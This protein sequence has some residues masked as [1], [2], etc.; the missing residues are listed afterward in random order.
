[1][2]SVCLCSNYN[3]IREWQITQP[4]KHYSSDG[5]HRFLHSLIPLSSS[6]FWQL[7]PSFICS[8]DRLY[9]D[10]LFHVDMSLSLSVWVEQWISQ[11][12]SSHRSSSEGGC[13]TYRQFVQLSLYW[14]TLSSWAGRSKFQTD[15]AD[16]SRGSTC[17]QITLIF[18]SLKTRGLLLILWMMFAKWE[19]R[20]NDGS[21]FCFASHFCERDTSRTSWRNFLKFSPNV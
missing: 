5:E 20:R 1:M 12:R 4:W 7:C 21:G 8:L 16:S 10:R 17:V 14:S 6:L 11:M 3:S 18:K 15:C 9:S 19:R 2:G 13:A